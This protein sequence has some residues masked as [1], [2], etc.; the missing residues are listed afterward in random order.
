M[1]ALKLIP[2]NISCSH[3]SLGKAAPS[4]SLFAKTLIFHL[5][6]FGTCRRVSAQMLLLATT[7]SSQSSFSQSLQPLRV[8]PPPPAS[9]THC[10]T[11]FTNMTSANT[12]KI[13]GVRPVSAS[14]GG[15]LRHTTMSPPSRASVSPFGTSKLPR[16]LQTP[17]AQRSSLP[18]RKTTPSPAHDKPLPSPPVAQLVDPNSPPKAARTLVDAYCGT[19]AWPA[20]QPENVP[21]RT[22]SKHASLPLPRAPSPT[23]SVISNSTWSQAAGSSLD[24]EEEEAESE[25][26]VKRLSW[27]TS[28]SGSGSGSGPVLTIQ[29]DAEALI[30][31][32]SNSIPDVPAIPNELPD[33]PL[34]PRSLS[35]L[36]G[37]LSRHT[38]SRLSS[39]NTSSSPAPT[40]TEFGPNG[41]PGIKI[42]PIRSMQPPRKASF[43]TPT[44]VG[45]APQISRDINRSVPGTSQNS[46]MATA[47]PDATAPA[48]CTVPESYGPSSAA[49]NKV[50]ASPRLASMH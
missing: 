50:C 18:V 41:S 31:G 32:R 34:Q 40:T 17:T 45:R 6:C 21:P 24:G 46:T 47:E 15:S 7:T 10:R 3:L 8:P 13:P 38:T 39:I 20:L 11:T 16:R 14:A 4:T 49:S 42:S 25:I 33:P 36:A 30:M 19:T 37:R 1:D 44:K 28:G 9:A 27:R 12:S 5:H 23:P 26:R 22:S 35:S 48:L 29:A 43:E 2:L